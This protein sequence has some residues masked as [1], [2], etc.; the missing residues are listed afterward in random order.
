MDFASKSDFIPRP[1]HLDGKSAVQFHSDLCR[2]YE[3]RD[4]EKKKNV[5]GHFFDTES[6]QIP[7]QT[8]KIFQKLRQKAQILEAVSTL[9]FSASKISRLNIPLVD[10]IYGRVV[11][12]VVRF[13]TRFFQKEMTEKEREL[14]PFLHQNP[15]LHL[16]IDPVHT[17]FQLGLS[18]FTLN[19]GQPCYALWISLKSDFLKG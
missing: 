9:K 15:G 3:I 16:T 19:L 10:N 7:R 13:A 11:L 12:A 14:I 6:A 2:G 4:T 1:L 8:A 18:P 17:T 5:T